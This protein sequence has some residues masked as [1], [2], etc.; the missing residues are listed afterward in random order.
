MFASRWHSPP[1]PAP[2]LSWVTG[3][4]SEREP[5]GVERALD[6]ALEH[7]RRARRRGRAAP[8][9]AATVLPAP[10]A[11][12]RFDDAH[13]GAV[14]VVAVGPRDRVVGVERVL[15]DPDLGRCIYIDRIFR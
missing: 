11:P 14:E 4:C 10:G 3:T 7:A 6:V 13:A 12:I 5:V 2:V 15:D 8:A 1:K 9:P